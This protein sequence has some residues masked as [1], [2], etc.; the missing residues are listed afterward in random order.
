MRQHNMREGISLQ[1]KN[2]ADVAVAHLAEY[3][4][5]R[6]EAQGRLNLSYTIVAADLATLA[7]GT[8]VIA[9]YPVILIALAMVSNFLFLFWLAQTMQ[10]YRIAAYVALRLRPSLMALYTCEVLGW[11]RYVRELTA[12]SEHM[13]RALYPENPEKAPKISRNRDGVYISLL[14]GGIAPPAL[15]GVS[16]FRARHASSPLWVW[17]AAIV[18]VAFWGY[19]MNSAI[20]VMRSTKHIS[21]VILSH[22]P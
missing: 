18:G 22:V 6:Q 17:L 7:A 8:S 10:I 19:A 3:Q 9:Q 4:A 20:N 5:L 11:E 21:D 16:L 1:S 12:S 13:A 15:I 14:L 2:G